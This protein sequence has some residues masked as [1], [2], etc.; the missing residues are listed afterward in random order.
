[1]QWIRGIGLK[2]VGNFVPGY[3]YTVTQSGTGYPWNYLLVVLASANVAY[4]ALPTISDYKSKTKPEAMPAL[5]IGHVKC[6]SV[7]SP[8]RAIVYLYVY[9]NCK[10]TPEWIMYAGLT[11]SRLQTYSARGSTRWLTGSDES[12]AMVLQHCS[13]H[14]LRICPRRA[15]AFPWVV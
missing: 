14:T 2:R 13:V 6:L 3:P 8:L 5:N 10:T 11:L 12:R 9:C 4:T 15:C 1:M 7:R